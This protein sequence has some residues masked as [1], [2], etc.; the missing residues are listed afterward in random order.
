MNHIIDFEFINA[1]LNNDNKEG[2]TFYWVEEEKDMM[3]SQMQFIIDCLTEIKPKTVLETGTNKANFV[4]LVKSIIKNCKIFTFDIHSWCGD[5]VDLVKKY[6][7]VD[8]IIFIC[9][10]TRKTLFDISL[11]TNK[12][13]LALVDGG[14]E[15][16]IAL[17][18]L[19]GCA[20]LKIPYIL[21]DDYNML[22]EVRNAVNFFIANKK[23]R[24][25]KSN[26]ENN[27]RG[28]VL[29]YKEIN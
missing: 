5:K 2:S 14:H 18:D 9:G 1:N 3:M 27:S 11:K 20:E 6:F 19:N 17:N 26:L 25:I 16:A 24:I 15:Y 8:D 4:F 7:N 29:L 22:E 23:Y 10:D 21:V 13:D 28:I 12:F